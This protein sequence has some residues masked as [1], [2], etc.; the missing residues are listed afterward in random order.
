MPQLLI[1]LQQMAFLSQDVLPD[2]QL[3][4]DTMGISL[5]RKWNDLGMSLKRNIML[6]KRKGTSPS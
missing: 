6:L 2:D 1:L 5:K 3:Q 4:R